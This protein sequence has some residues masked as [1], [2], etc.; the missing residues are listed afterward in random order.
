MAKDAG[1]PIFVSPNNDEN[2]RAL[3]KHRGVRLLILLG[4]VA[5][6]ILE[7]YSSAGVWECDGKEDQEEIVRMLTKS[8]RVWMA[9]GDGLANWNETK[10]VPVTFHSK[11]VA[12]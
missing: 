12:L 1:L 8:K 11:F 2:N 3:V 6:P 7:E 9:I 5:L 10:T 4:P